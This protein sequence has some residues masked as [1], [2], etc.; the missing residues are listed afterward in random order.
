ML[1]ISKFLFFMLMLGFSEI[2]YADTI[3]LSPLKMCDYTDM[4]GNSSNFFPM[5]DMRCD[6]D[7]NNNHHQNGIGFGVPASIGWHLDNTPNG[8]YWDHHVVYFLFELPSVPDG[9]SVSDIKLDLS[10]LERYV[11]SKDATPFLSVYISPKVST[12]PQ[13]MLNW[14]TAFQLPQPPEFPQDETSSCE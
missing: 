9:V 8:E 13:N 7:S 4:V 11:G 6:I 2:V 3:T 10:I 12:D 5:S 14:D 1:K